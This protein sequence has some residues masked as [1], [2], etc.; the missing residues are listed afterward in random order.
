[1]KAAEVKW[2]G[3]VYGACWGYIPNA[4]VFV[5]DETGDQ[6]ILDPSGFRP[7]SGA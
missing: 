6:G 5:I 4:G 7:V 3:K 1:M 2:E